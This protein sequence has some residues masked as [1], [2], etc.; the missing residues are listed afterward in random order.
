MKN[1]LHGLASLIA[2][3]VPIVLI[4]FGP[5]WQGLTLGAVLT[6][7]YHWSLNYLSA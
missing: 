7:L 1:V 6:G 4:G 3:W 2:F 5:T